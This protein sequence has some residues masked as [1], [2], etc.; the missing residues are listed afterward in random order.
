VREGARGHEDGLR[1][2]CGG[3]QDWNVVGGEMIIR[4]LKLVVAIPIYVTL[5][6]CSAEEIDWFVSFCFGSTAYLIADMAV[7][8]WE[9]RRR[10]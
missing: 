8:G 2:G 7:D 10:P 9:A 4:L 5:R 1:G 6:A 3:A